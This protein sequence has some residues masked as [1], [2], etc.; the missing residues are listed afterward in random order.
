MRRIDRTVDFIGGALQ[1]RNGRGPANLQEVRGARDIGAH[2]V[3]GM[4]ERAIDMGL[5]REIEDP[6]DAVFVNEARDQFVVDNVALHEGKARILVGTDEV[7]A[8]PGVGELVQH[9]E[10]LESFHLQ[11]VSGERRADEA[12]AASEQ[13]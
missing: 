8:V 7:S 3:T 11:K 5:G 4:L 1:K 9:D 6:I 2:K 12:G 13:D 10:A